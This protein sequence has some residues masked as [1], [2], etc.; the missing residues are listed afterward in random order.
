MTHPNFTPLQ[1][2]S[3]TTTFTGFPR[4]PHQAAV[5]LVAR[6]F[7]AD[8]PTRMDEALIDA[9]GYVEFY[10]LVQRGFLRIEI[11]DGDVNG[12]H[13]VEHPP[14]PAPRRARVAFDADLIV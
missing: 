1:K 13:V 4:D 7:S 5:E 2:G 12:V 14:D 3:V 10:D 8:A 11:V 6:H 9:V